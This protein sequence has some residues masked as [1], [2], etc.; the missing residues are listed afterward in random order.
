M[1]W[2]THISIFICNITHVCSDFICREL[3]SKAEPPHIAQCT[4]SA[5]E[6]TVGVKEEVGQSGIG[7]QDLLESGDDEAVRLPTEE[8]VG[9]LDKKSSLNKD[10]GEGAE[11]VGEV[12]KL[13]DDV[14]LS[15]GL[16]VDMGEE[17]IEEEQELSEAGGQSVPVIGRKMTAEDT[18]PQ[19][20][21]EGTFF[22]LSFCT[23]HK[24]NIFVSSNIHLV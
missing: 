11:S 1:L 5:D 22:V 14:C 9:V 4:S 24:I 8:E 2:L 21:I 6:I 10:G 17:K 13:M 3:G 18:P 12:G 19:N 16:F 15:G 20:P 7:S 23:S